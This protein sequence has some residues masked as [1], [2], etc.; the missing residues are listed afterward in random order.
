MRISFFAVLV[1]RTVLALVFSTL[2]ALSIFA[3]NPSLPSLQTPVVQI[4]PYF[5]DEEGRYISPSQ[6]SG[7]IISSDGFILTNCHVICDMGEDRGGCENISE[8]YPSANLIVVL[9]CV[10]EASPPVARYVAEIVGQ[11]RILD[12]ALLKIRQRIRFLTGA[13]ADRNLADW[14][15]ALEFHQHSDIFGEQYRLEEIVDLFLPAISLGDSDSIENGDSVKTYGYPALDT[16]PLFTVTEGIVSQRPEEERF[17]LV[18]RAFAMGGSSGGAVVEKASG[19]LVAVLCGGVEKPESEYAGELLLRA[20]PLNAVASVLPEEVCQHPL[21]EFTYTPQNPSL[22]QPVAF[23]ASASKS[24]DA[25]IE[26]YEWDFDGDGA[27]EKEGKEKTK[28]FGSPGGLETVSR[29]VTLRVTNNRGYSS[30]VTHVVPL[31]RDWFPPCE[32]RIIRGNE[33]KT[34][35]FQYLQQCIDAAKEGETVVISSGTHR[36]GLFINKSLTLKADGQAVLEGDAQKPVISIVD[37]QNVTIE[38]LTLVNGQSGIRVEDSIGI[39]IAGNTLRHNLGKGIVLQESQAEITGNE[40]A[41]T[42]QDP[43]DHGGSALELVD[44]NETLGSRIADNTLANNAASGISL[45]NASAEIQNNKITA[46]LGSGVSLTYGSDATLFNNAISENVGHGVYIRDSTSEIRSSSITATQMDCNKDFGHGI[47]VEGTEGNA[48]EAMIADSRIADNE[49]SG[50]FVER[51]IATISNTSISTNTVGVLARQSGCVN[52][53]DSDA[54][55]NSYAGLWLVGSANASQTRS[56]ISENTC[57]GVELLGNAAARLNSS[58]VCDNGDAGL[59]LFD[60]SEVFLN[61]TEIARNCT[62]QDR[63]KGGGLV[64]WDDAEAKLENDCGVSGNGSSGIKLFGSS[65][66]FLNRSTVASNADAGLEIFGSA[67]ASL[68]DSTVSSNEK[69]GMQVSNESQI[70]VKDCWISDNGSYGIHCADY[71][72]VEG[73]GNWALHNPKG[74]FGFTAPQGFLREEEPPLLDEVRVGPQGCDFSEIGPAIWSLRPGGT[75]LVEEGNYPG[76]LVLVKDLTIIG[77]G[78]EETRI[79]NCLWNGISIAGSAVVALSDLSI[80]ENSENGLEV[81]SSARLSLSEARVYGNREGIFVRDRAA[82]QIQGCV[83]ERN[84]C[85]GLWAW[86]NAEVTLQN[87]HIV[88]NTF[89]VCPYRQ[90]LQGAVELLHN[91]SATISGN[92]IRDNYNFGIEL[93]N[94]ALATIEKNKILDNS[95]WGL[96]LIQPSNSEYN[97]PFTGSVDGSGNTFLGNGKLLSDSDKELGDGV[98]DLCSGDLDLEFLKEEPDS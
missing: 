48:A 83:I 41:N 62:N 98:G 85:H 66:A 88:E 50:L 37:A 22:G 40:I 9:V 65:F 94:A 21:A 80:G 54:I 71:A 68:A 67:R 93:A 97:L 76:G 60:T 2:F 5:L 90:E 78:T 30:T 95:R 49:Q 20:R 13:K 7:C 1:S 15:K 4:V 81:V 24:I 46:N 10:D 12:I 32:C 19:L 75:V 25:Y 77:A 14:A 36:G 64:L 39:Q 38:G 72:T 11:D 63:K 16:L 56:S 23:D 69:A 35:T 28:T 29:P 73:Y 86:N 26:K 3:Q 34:L 84:T 74:L 61:D 44:I 70:E 57:V 87:S 47:A 51:A 17:I 27:F 42:M 52:M 18:D 79:S 82:V 92:E 8:A 6:G 55:A 59:R 96:I 33:K 89:S 45:S 43:G 31:H 91:A 53:E 58:F